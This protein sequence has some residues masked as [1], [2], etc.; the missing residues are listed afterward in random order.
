MTIG[1]AMGERE[2]TRLVPVE[3]HREL[4][5]A[6]RTQ[7]GNEPGDAV[8]GDDCH[9]AGIFG[10]HLLVVGVVADQRFTD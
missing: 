8:V 2:L 4:T 7:P 6:H 1:I 9:L 5:L 3:L 10:D